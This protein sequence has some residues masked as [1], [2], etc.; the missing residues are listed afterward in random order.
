MIVS[1]Q[2]PFDRS[3]LGASSEVIPKLKSRAT[4][5]RVR[6]MKGHG[7]QFEWKKKA[8]S[9]PCSRKQ[10]LQFQ[11]NLE[12]GDRSDQDQSRRLLPRAVCSREKSTLL[13]RR[14]DVE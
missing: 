1:K 8:R 9:S 4:C 14:F 13:Q 6:Q 2:I 5:A 10:L 3:A 11:T 12:R 7:T